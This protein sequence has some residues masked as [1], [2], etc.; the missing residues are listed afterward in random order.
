M[1]DW[2]KRIFMKPESIVEVGSTDPVRVSETLSIVS[3]HTSYLSSESTESAVALP[4]SE[5]ALTG[6]LLL[7]FV[8]SRGQWSPSMP[9][10]FTHVLTEAKPRYKLGAMVCQKKWRGTRRAVLLPRSEG[11]TY[12]SLVIIRGA[13]GIL[14]SKA[15]MSS[16]GLSRTYSPRVSTAAKGCQIVGF[17]YLGDDSK[18]ISNADPL[19]SMQHYKHGFCL[20]SRETTGGLSE[21]VYADGKEYG[22]ADIAVSISLF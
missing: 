3:V 17:N 4:I 20:A 15:K 11:S 7:L 16:R 21:R 19:V 6:D 5:V 18:M 14:D 13:K 1:I 12:Y 9:H 8:L 22:Q 2:F 10:G